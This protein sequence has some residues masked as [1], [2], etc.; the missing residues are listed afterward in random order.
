MLSAAPGMGENYEDP[1]GTTQMARMRL[2]RPKNMRAS[3][4]AAALEGAARPD[5]SAKPLY[6][7]NYDGAQGGGGGAALGALQ[8]MRGEVESDDEDDGEGRYRAAGIG[9]PLPHAVGGSQSRVLTTSS[10]TAFML[11]QGQARRPAA[12]TPAVAASQ[13]PPLPAEDADGGAARSAV[14]DAVISARLKH[15]R[16]QVQQREETTV[17][18]W[19]NGGDKGDDSDS[20]L[21]G[22]G[23]SGGPVGSRRASAEPAEGEEAGEEAEPLSVDDGE[24]LPAAAQAE[25]APGKLSAEEISARQLEQARLFARNPTGWLRT[26]APAGEMLQCVVTRDRSGFDLLFPQYRCYLQ[27]PEGDRFLMAARK[28]KKSNSNN[29]VI[30][31]SMKDLARCGF[32]P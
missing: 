21:E 29:Y 17:D 25:A 26:P 4:S 27:T 19:H 11:R 24:S 28:R 14:S 30:S 2:D 32:T 1:A 6:N 13:P 20:D 10:S 8:A 9:Q 12:A 5:A 31:S 18:P 23:D 16:Q 15:A 3:A 7:L 22:E